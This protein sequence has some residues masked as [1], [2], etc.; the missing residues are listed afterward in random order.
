M[1]HILTLCV[2]LDKPACCIAE[3]SL[4]SSGNV[5]NILVGIEERFVLR[6]SPLLNL[7]STE[8]VK[9]HVRKNLWFCMVKHQI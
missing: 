9:V 6:F 5:G 8:Y 7:V 1:W 3:L 2:S 4:N